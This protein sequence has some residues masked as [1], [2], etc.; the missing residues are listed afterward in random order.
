M[1]LGLVC[2]IPVAQASSAVPWVAQGSV[3]NV[4]DLGDGRLA[5]VGNFQRRGLLTGPLVQI[6]AGEIT[7]AFPEL[8]GTI[9]HI[10]PDPRGGF[11]VGGEFVVDAESTWQNLVRVDA[12]G[13]LD[14]HWNPNPNGAVY[15]I[16]VNEAGVFV[17]GS[18]QTIAGESRGAVARFS[19]DGTLD[20]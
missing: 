5:H 18:F 7:A 14:P 9:H 2:A 12:G 16:E 19:P 15:A 10:Q 20:D 1:I 11:Y 6:E 13:R 4:L 17:G 8:V 3:Q